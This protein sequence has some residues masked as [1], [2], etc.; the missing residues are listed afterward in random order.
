MFFTK[1]NRNLEKLCPL[2]F[3]F[4]DN[5]INIIYLRKLIGT[6]TVRVLRQN[7]NS[8]KYFIVVEV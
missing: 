1:M 7:T 8:K 4:S 3:S 6:N 5:I 2:S